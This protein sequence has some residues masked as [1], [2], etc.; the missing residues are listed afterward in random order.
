LAPEILFLFWK[1]EFGIIF[2]FVSLQNFISQQWN[3]ALFIV[4]TKAHRGQLSKD[5]QNKYFDHKK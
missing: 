1:K 4:L 3:R 5:K 2:I